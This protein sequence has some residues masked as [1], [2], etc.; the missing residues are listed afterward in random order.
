MDKGKITQQIRKYFEPNERE[1]MSY[2]NLR[3]TAKVVLTGKFKAL[4]CLY[5]KNGNV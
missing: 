3:E 4:K 5:Q 2:Q 1:N